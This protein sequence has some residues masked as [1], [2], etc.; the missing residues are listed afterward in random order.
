[1]FWN[2]VKLECKKAVFNRF[3]VLSVV[4]GIGITFWSLAPMVQS[5]TQDIESHRQISQEF[6]E[7]NPLMPMESLFCH[8]IGGEPCSTGT[9]SYFF[10]FP[11]LVCL[12]YGWSFC[13]ERR[14][15][16]IKNMVI[17]SGK[18][19]YFLAKYTALFLSGGLA[20]VIPLLFNFLLA[21]VLFPA[22]TPNVI[23]DTAYGIGAESFLSMV[24]YTKPF[25]YVAAYLFVDFVFGGLTACLCLSISTVIKNPVAVTLLPFFLLLGVN[26]VC[27]SIIYRSSTVIYRE[28]S[29]MVF[30]RPAPAAY[31]TT[32]G[33]VFGW[34]AVLFVLTFSM[35]VLRGTRREI[36]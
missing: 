16:Y 23:Y 19:Q 9:S 10:L 31:D 35:G 8:W 7:R 33:I 30:L 25:L 2:T 22:I 4:I 14:S 21:A 36:Y 20:M 12:P 32:A 18:W 27:Y 29:P 3:F 11:L 5:Y 17:R 24:F 6:G 34:A 13:R 15:G 26:Y 1:M 28:L